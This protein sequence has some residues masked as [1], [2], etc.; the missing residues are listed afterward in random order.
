MPWVS[1]LGDAAHQRAMTT[2]PWHLTWVAHAG[3]LVT[4]LGLVLVA[5]AEAMGEG[6]WMIKKEGRGE[7]PPSLANGLDDEV[8]Q[9]LAGVLSAANRGDG[10]SFLKLV[11]RFDAGLTDQRRDE[12]SAYLYYLLRYRV[13]EVL[14]RR[15]VAEDLHDLAVQTHPRYAKVVTEPVGTLEDTL[16]AVFNMPPTGL[17]Q[18]GAGLF[19]SGVAAA[20]VLLRDPSVDLAPIRSH[21]AEWRSRRG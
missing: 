5:A 2:V 4:S 21:L 12:A 3:D 8:W 20:G 6:S 1:E 18:S 9:R 17:Q 16:R 14:G 7:P 13:A 19:V 11:K 15:P 10:N